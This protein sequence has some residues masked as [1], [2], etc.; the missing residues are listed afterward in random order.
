MKIK[1]L[2]LDNIDIGQVTLP[3]QFTEQIR[4]D[5][6]KRAVLAIQ[7]NKRQAYG[8][9]VDSGMKHSSYISRRRRKYRGSYGLGIARVP[10]KIHSRS[11]TRMNWT[12][13]GVPNVVGGRPGHPPQ[14]NKVWE[15]KINQ[16]EKRM[17]IRSA[18]AA[19]IV[20]DTVKSRGHRIPKGYPFIIEDKAEDL[21]STKAIVIV[22]NKLGLTEELDRVSE[23]K[24][25]PGKGKMRGRR[26]RKKSGPLLVVSKSCPLSKGARNIPGVEIAIVDKLNTEMLAPGT[27]PGRLTIWT[28][29]AIQRLEKE[30]LFCKR[31]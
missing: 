27:V 3:E 28:E 15:Q 7:A 24:E 14:I 1:K 19:T 25:R 5:L 16:T 10:R 26:F 12:A 23:A 8:S 21:K 18:I 13:A 30:K 29:G 4:P 6:I 31:K 22:L 20:N 17:A 2:T 9:D 11:G